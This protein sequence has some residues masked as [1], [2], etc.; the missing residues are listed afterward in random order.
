MKLKKGHFIDKFKFLSV[1]VAVTASNIGRLLRRVKRSSSGEQCHFKVE[2]GVSRAA[3]VCQE[4]EFLAIPMVHSQ[5][6]VGVSDNRT[7]RTGTFSLLPYVYHKHKLKRK[8]PATI[9]FAVE[10]VP[11]E[12]HSPIARVWRSEG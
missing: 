7:N 10:N 3:S 4:P 1:A 5:Y 12:F 8:A 2:S 9:A 6:Y 11:F